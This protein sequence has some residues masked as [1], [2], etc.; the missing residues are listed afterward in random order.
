MK[1]LS[2]IFQ[3]IKDNRRAYIVINVLYYGLVAVGM[4]YVSFNPALQQTLLAAVG[5][6]F[7]EGPLSAV[8]SAYGSGE[9]LRA[10]LLTFVVNLFAGSLLVITLPSLLIP[11]FG[12]AMGMYRAVLWG[13]LLSP[14]EP[15]LALSMIPHSLTLLLEGQAYIVAIFAAYLLWRNF[16][17]PRRAGVES[18]S[19]GYLLGLKQTGILYIGVILLLAVAAIYEALEVIYLVPLMY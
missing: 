11:F 14:S 12:L 10:M 9:V 16:F 19:R 4:V 13:L 1:L 6:S 15:T 7:T 8:G 5:Q 3:I 2:N 18:R 17:W